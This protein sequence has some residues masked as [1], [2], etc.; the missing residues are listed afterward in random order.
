LPHTDGAQGHRRDRLNSPGVVRLLR[1]RVGP[2]ATLAQ[3]LLQPGDLDDSAGTTLRR[4]RRAMRRP[5]PAER[6]LLPRNHPRAGWQEDQTV[7]LPAQGV[8]RGPDLGTEGDARDP[9]PHPA[10][11]TSTSAA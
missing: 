7:A 3:H 1:S 9:Q 10:G 4:T 11:P 8:T 6:T 2:D 5:S